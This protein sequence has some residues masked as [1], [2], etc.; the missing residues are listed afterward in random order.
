MPPAKKSTASRA[1]LRAK[2]GRFQNLSSDK[3][4][5]GY[6]TSDEIAKWVCEWTIEDGFYPEITDGCERV[7]NFRS[8]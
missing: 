2:A 8:C 5:G 1:P 4:R 7:E 6:Y 3:L